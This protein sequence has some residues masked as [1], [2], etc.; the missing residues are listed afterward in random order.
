[1]LRQPHG[2]TGTT[3]NQANSASGNAAQDA[4]DTATGDIPGDLLQTLHSL[5]NARRDNVGNTVADRVSGTGGAAPANGPLPSANELLGALSVLQSQ[6]ATTVAQPSENTGARD[7]HLNQE[8]S[9]LKEQLLSQL[10]ALRGARPSHVANI[11]EDT[12][13]LVGMLFEFIL[14]DHNLPPEMQALLAR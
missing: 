14:E 4:D 13:D 8:V 9:Q 11:D 1:M 2:S 5:F 10:G 12:I 7:A 3:G 6:L